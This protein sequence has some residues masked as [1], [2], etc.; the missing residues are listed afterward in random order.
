MIR[1]RYTLFTRVPVYADEDGAIWAARLWAKDLDLHLGYIEDF[2]LCCPVEPMPQDRSDLVRV[3]GLERSRV[4][5]VRRDH[6]WGSVLRNL[7][8]N[9]LTVRRAVAASQIVHSGGAG[10]AF[11][12]SFYIL[13]LSF[14]RRFFW[15]IVIESSFWMK[16]AHGRVT[17]RQFLSHHLHAGLLGWSLR[18]AQ[19]RIFTQAGYREFFG[20]GPERSLIA[21]AVWID[22]E[23]ILSP[24]AQAAR[25]AALPRT[26]VRFLFPARLVAEKGVDTI[27]KAI[28]L[29]SDRI[30]GQEGPPQIEIDL[31][32]QGPMRETCGAF[33]AD[34]S[35][36]LTVRLLDPLPY[37]AEFFAL[38][39][40]YHGVLL[41]NRQREQPRIIFDVY[42]QGVPVISSDTDGVRQVSTDGEDA[43]LYPVDDAEAL[44]E[45]VL[46][47]AGDSALQERLSNQALERVR[48]FSQKRMHEDREAFLQACLQAA[49]EAR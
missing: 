26:P 14:T 46:R 41:A 21:P 13:P 23:V 3:E 5:P 8:P 47:F 6:G 36:P 12:M 16:P 22:D 29:L 33:V 39:R 35:G 10:W 45:A 7:I 31:I 28:G 34:H 37:G 49:R 38:L 1:E 9:F 32:G 11:P 27:L 30:A 15:I 18:R 44:V 4:I 2:H 43:L 25:L 17:L 48:G 42:S 40:G 20:I 19:A 24:E